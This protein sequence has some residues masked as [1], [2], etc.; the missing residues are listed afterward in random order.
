MRPPE[1]WRRSP[2]S[3]LARLLAPFARRYG[4]I[5]ADRMSRPG[6]A[7]GLPTIVVG[8]FTLGGDGKTPAALAI[9]ELLAET[10]ERP[11]FLTRGYGRSGARREPFSVDL[12]RDGAAEAGDEPMLLA[13]KAPTIVGADRAAGAGLARD[14]GASVLLLDDGLQ[15]RR[16]EPDLSF[17]VVDGAYGV[18][19]GL[20]L[21]AGPLRASLLHQ[22][23][24][25]DA[26][27]VIGWG[28]AGES[29]AHRARAEG[30]QLFRARITPT[31][32]IVAQLSARRVF[33]FAGIARPE[34]FLATL[35][36]V[37]AHIV[38]VRWF[39]D[40]HR[41]TRGDL[42]RLS[43]A[44]L[45]LNARLVT[46]EKD[47]VRLPDARD[48]QIAALPIRLAFDEPKDVGAALQEMLER[49]R[50]SRGA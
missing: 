24:A 50:V 8:G 44:A 42:D 14:L 19:N 45:R 10:G 41:Y 11:A 40:H 20:C 27:I 4:A 47:A 30:K 21:P 43:R 7:A 1:F 5:A 49:V 16:L 9:A 23:Q 12:S 46:T 34:K 26:A 2:P 36:E 13:Q 15:S 29:V 28:D 39:A 25:V 31:G 17:A 35:R 37:G 33:A 18:G 38:G 48:P 3:P 22:L 6:A 32:P